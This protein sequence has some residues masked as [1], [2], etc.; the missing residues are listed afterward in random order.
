MYNKKIK[1]FTDLDVWKRAHELV[2]LTYKL[3]QSFPKDERYVLVPQM[4]R[5]AISITS[6]IAEGF[7]RRTLKDKTHFYTIAAGSLIELINQMIL[8]KDLGYVSLVSFEQF[9]DQKTDVHKLLN[10]FILKTRAFQSSSL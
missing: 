9:D 3:T 10:A 2:K 6:N 4:R 8:A 1:E 7:G 5:A